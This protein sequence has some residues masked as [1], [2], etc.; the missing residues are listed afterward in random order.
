M[1]MASGTAAGVPSFA[2]AACHAVASPASP[3]GTLNRFGGTLPRVGLVA[4]LPSPRNPGASLYF[5]RTSDMAAPRCRLIA[6]TTTTTIGRYQA[7]PAA[8]EAARPGAS[9]VRL[10]AHRK[11]ECGCCQEERSSCGPAAIDD[12]NPA[13]H[14]AG[15]GPYSY[16]PPGPARYCQPGRPA[17][18]DR[19]RLGNRHPISGVWRDG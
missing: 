6:A 4:L 1:S 14:V 10:T 11:P 8:G 19:G 9:A 2:P 7:I 3:S 15:S 16:R 17:E 12:Q 18:L 5:S 13:G